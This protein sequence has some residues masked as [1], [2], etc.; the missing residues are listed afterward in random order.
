MNLSILLLRIPR[1][2]AS[3]L[4]ESGLEL[5][6]LLLHSLGQLS[7]HRIIGCELL[8]FLDIALQLGIP[9]VLQLVPVP[10]GAAPVL[11][12]FDLFVEELGASVPVVILIED[13]LEF[14][15][16]GIFLLAVLVLA[17]V[18]DVDEVLV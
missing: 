18:L 16:G 10:E 9:P 14:I 6:Q 3:K 15:E 8:V 13:L 7:D 1:S 11:E 17:V 5:S 2:L 12:G 4:F